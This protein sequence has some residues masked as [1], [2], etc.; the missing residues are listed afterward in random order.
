MR[1]SSNALERGAL[2]GAGLDVFEKEP[3]NPGDPLVQH[4]KCVTTPHLGASTAEAQAN[5]A[6]AI[7]HQVIEA[8]T[9]GE[10]R[11]AINIP[12][13][14][15]KVRS[16]LAPYLVVGEKL[17]L[18]GIQL[19]SRHPERVELIYS[20]ELGEIDTS[21]LTVTILKGLLTPILE[22]TVN[23]VNAPFLAK[24]RGIVYSE[25]KTQETE[26]FSSLVTVRLKTK[27]QVLT[28]SGTNLAPHDPRIVRVDGYHIDAKPTGCLLFLRNTDEP[29]IIGHVGTILGRAKINIADLTLG[30]KEPGGA[31]VTVCN[32]DQQPDDAVLK[33]IGTIPQVL[34]VKM[35]NLR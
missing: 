7:A 5:V 18:F 13:V 34:D 26:G 30:R 20:G 23:D 16:V 6:I 1:A 25:T 35:V 15:P 32:V 17:G 22:E 8:L 24:Q 14:D 4:P 10:I 3:P 27:D 2:G 28:L 19:L 12:S 31:A 9:G 33:E 21:L 29:G 11:N